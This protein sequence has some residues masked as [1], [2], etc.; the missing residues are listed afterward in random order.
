M[1]C[2]KPQRVD[3][4]KSPMLF[5][6]Y[7]A[8]SVSLCHEAIYA[9]AISAVGFGSCQFLRAVTWGQSLPDLH[10]NDTFS[11]LIGRPSKALYRHY[12]ELVQGY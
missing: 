3:H 8:G 10:L 1:C 9:L 6:A 12:I 7:V 11:N 4:G 5:E 2:E